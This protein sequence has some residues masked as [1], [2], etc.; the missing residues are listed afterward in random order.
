MGFMMSVPLPI[1]VFTELCDYMESN[2]ISDD[3]GDVLGQFVLDWIRNEKNTAGALKPGE[4]PTMLEGFQWKELFL[5]AGTRLRTTYKRQRHLAEVVGDRIMFAG[6]DGT[7]SS[8]ANAMSTNP[9]SAWRTIW[10]LFPGERAWRP[11]ARCLAE[12]IESSKPGR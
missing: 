12:A 3:F 4:L 1:D 8:F 9:R 11:A 5:P 2:Y 7:P 10:L 6:K